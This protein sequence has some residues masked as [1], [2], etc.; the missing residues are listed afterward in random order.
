MKIELTS[1]PIDIYAVSGLSGIIDVQN[2]SRDDIRVSAG[3]TASTSLS[4]Y[5]IM[6]HGDWRLFDDL[7]LMA[8][9]D[10]EG[11][12]IIVNQNTVSPA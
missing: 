12:E 4:E 2:L 9:A 8:Y 11:S 3:A 10:D 7:T 1:T 6:L 5:N